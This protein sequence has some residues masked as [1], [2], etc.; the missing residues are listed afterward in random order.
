VLALMLIAA[1]SE[2]RENGSPEVFQ[3]EMAKKP[4]SAFSSIHQH[5][6]PALGSKIKSNSALSHLPNEHARQ[7]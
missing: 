4:Q 1:T 7:G 5:K 2:A 6:T 3:V